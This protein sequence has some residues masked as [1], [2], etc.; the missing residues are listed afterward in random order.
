MHEWKD[1]LEISE[2]AFKIRVKEMGKG[3]VRKKRR[4]RSR[5]DKVGI[6]VLQRDGKYE[7]N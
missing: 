6:D 5:N 3:K 4:K 2:L 1:V 7:G